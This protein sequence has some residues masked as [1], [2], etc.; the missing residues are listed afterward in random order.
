MS[1]K[2]QKFLDYYDLPITTIVEKEVNVEFSMSAETGTV[3]ADIQIPE[4]MIK[5]ER[6]KVTVYHSPVANEGGSYSGTFQL[7]KLE[8]GVSLLTNSVFTYTSASSSFQTYASESAP[9]F[10]SPS[11][12]PNFWGKT[13]QLRY[14]NT[15]SITKDKKSLVRRVKIEAYTGYSTRYSVR[16]MDSSVRKVQ[17]I[18]VNSIVNPTV[19]S[20]VNPEKTI[21]IPPVRE[22]TPIHIKGDAEGYHQVIEFY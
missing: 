21:V 9:I 1:W 5:F 15:A 12:F 10:L 3:I 17:R 4:E 8:G 19:I 13:V 7:Y 18:N 16:Q 2:E 14:S 22:L 6:L 20:A 11:H